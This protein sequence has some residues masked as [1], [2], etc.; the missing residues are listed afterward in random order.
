MTDTPNSQG[1]D[2][3]INGEDYLFAEL[4]L[5]AIAS[6][7]PAPSRKRFLIPLTSGRKYACDD[8]YA[9]TVALMI[10]IDFC[11]G[12]RFLAREPRQSGRRRQNAA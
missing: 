7:T 1:F 4:E 11:D 3:V 8:G 2:I 9:T 10:T 5:S 6:A 12:N